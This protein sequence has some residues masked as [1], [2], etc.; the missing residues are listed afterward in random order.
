MKHS[1][2]VHPAAHGDIWEIIR[3]YATIHQS[4]PGASLALEFWAAFN[5]HLAR[6]IDHPE[7]YPVHRS[8]IR[9][10]NLAP[11]FKNYY[12]AYTIRR[13][14]IIILAVGHAKRRPNYWRDRLDEV[15]KIF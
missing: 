5:S 3:Y 8:S 14:R 12:I 1:Y 13:G 11:R 7:L 2:E 15:P 9:R 6:V 10:V 4:T